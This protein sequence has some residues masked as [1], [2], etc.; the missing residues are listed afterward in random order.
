MEPRDTPPSVEP[1]S[2]EHFPPAAGDA[3]HAESREETVRKAVA[4]QR[5]IV[6]TQG[7]GMAGDPLADPSTRRGANRGFLRSGLG[8]AVTGLVLGALL[9]CIALQFDT[10]LRGRGAGAEDSGVMGNIGDAIHWV[11]AFSIALAIIGFLLGTY[12]GLEREDGRVERQVEDAQD[13]PPDEA[14]GRPLDPKHDVGT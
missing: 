2:V 3:A 6:G 5:E 14:H 4:E 1:A 11:I 10:P 13:V 8:G 9:A 7:A 12:M